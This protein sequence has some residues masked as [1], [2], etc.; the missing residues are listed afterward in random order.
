MTSSTGHHI[1]ISVG[2]Q[3][4]KI[5]VASV[6]KSISVTQAEPGLVTRAGAIPCSASSS[7]T[8]APLGQAA[9][10]L[11]CTARGRG[12]HAAVTKDCGFITALVLYP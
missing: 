8:Q 2:L 11:H 3:W 12:T 5:T 10:L 6:L 1:R 9:C 4:P 7:E